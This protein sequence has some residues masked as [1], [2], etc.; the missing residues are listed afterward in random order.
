VQFHHRARNAGQTGD[1]LAA[2]LSPTVGLRQKEHVLHDHRHALEIFE[3]RAQHISQRVGIACF[4]QSN[5][6]A[7]H[8][9]RQR[10]E[11]FMRNI[12]IEGFQLPV[13]C[14]VAPPRVAS[15]VKAAT[16]RR[17]SKRL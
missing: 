9:R 13:P 5:F 16:T 1:M 6:S 14:A 8:Q 15:V 7:P 3:V 2:G 17:I 12:S 4:A 11:Q 10:R